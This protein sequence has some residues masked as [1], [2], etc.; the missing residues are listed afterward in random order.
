MATNDEGLSP[1]GAIV[2]GLIFIALGIYLIHQI[3][4]GAELR[5]KEYIG[6]PVCLLFGIVCLVLGIARTIRGRG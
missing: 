5:P 3:V 6:G 1:T 4:S 2:F